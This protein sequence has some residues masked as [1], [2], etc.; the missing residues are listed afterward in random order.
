MP[1]SWPIRRSRV[2]ARTASLIGTNGAS[3]AKYLRRTWLK[4]EDV[5]QSPYWGSAGGPYRPIPRDEAAQ[6]FVQVDRRLIPQ[7]PASLRNV[8]PGK[9]NVPWLLGHLLANGAA[10]R[11][12][13]EAVN[14]LV[15]RYRV[16]IPQVENVERHLRGVSWVKRESSQDASDKVVDIGVVAPGLT[17]A[18]DR[19][20]LT[21][22]EQGGELIDG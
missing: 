2:L 13:L 4:I 8:G 5:S 6:T 15:E 20:G 18:K 9:R 11:S 10:T 21:G 14:K 16:G 7:H 1:C 19:K 3:S 22:F 12:V 17:V